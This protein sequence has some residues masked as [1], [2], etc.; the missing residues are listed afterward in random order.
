MVSELTTAVFNYTTSYP[1]FVI[2]FSHY[3]CT[4][5]SQTSSSLLVSFFAVIKQEY[6]Q[7]FLNQESLMLTG[8]WRA[9]RFDQSSTRLNSAL[10]EASG[11]IC[12]WKRIFLG[13]FHIEMKER[14]ISDLADGK[15]FQYWASTASCVYVCLL[16]SHCAPQKA[17]GV[18]FIFS[19]R[20]SSF[21]F[22]IFI[23]YIRTQNNNSLPHTSVA[24]VLQTDFSVSKPRMLT[25]TLCLKRILTLRFLDLGKLRI[26]MTS[27]LTDHQGT[28]C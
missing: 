23:V 26:S 1:T 24:A 11:S 15:S 19:F 2:N 12:S 3:P 21:T 8:Y 5:C 4:N 14:R 9:S 18:D 13:L 7:H 25:F 6:K 20:D 10:S 27:Y 28:G 22:S 16:W 17:P